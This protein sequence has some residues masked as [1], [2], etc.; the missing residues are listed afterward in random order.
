MPKPVVARLAGPARAGGLGLAAACDIAVCTREATFAFTE[1]RLGLV[2]ASISGVVLPRMDPRAAHELFLTGETFD[3]Q[4]AVAI[5]LV[6]ACPPA[7]ELDAV[8]QRYVDALLLAEPNAAAG[9]KAMLA[10]RWAPDLAEELA[11]LADT[12]AAYFASEAAREG[13]RAF[14]EKRPPRWVAPA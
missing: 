2:A 6:N 10:G 7:E 5:G 3:A 13:M 8:V 1:I 9:T 12:S 4:R 14:T 11:A